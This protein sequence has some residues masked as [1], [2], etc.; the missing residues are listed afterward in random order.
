MGKAKKR[1]G[2]PASEVLTPLL[3]PLGALQRILQKMD[4]RGVIIGGIAASLL[5]QPRFT[6]DLDAVVF[7]SIEELP[8][9]IEIASSEGMKPRIT[10]A[11]S[12]ARKNRVLLLQHELSNIKVDISL[13]ILPFES[14]MIERG[15]DTVVGPL[16]LRLPTP[17]DLIIMK[18]VA[19]RPKDLADIQAIVTSHPDLDRE[20]IRYWVEEFGNVLDLPDLWIQISQLL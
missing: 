16:T 1:G 10:D 7:L 17:E 15:Q 3:E 5:G 4:N 11:E 19:H 14:E 20:R 9:L 13:G 6:A 2:Q 18:A 8:R 12:F